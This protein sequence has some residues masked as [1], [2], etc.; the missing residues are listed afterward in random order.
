MTLVDGH[1]NAFR[2]GKGSREAWADLAGRLNV[3]E[4]LARAGIASDQVDTFSA[5]LQ[6]LAAVHKRAHG[7]AA[8]WT[9]RGPE[10]AALDDGLWM[11]RVQLQHCSQGELEHARQRV[12]RRMQQA[13][14]GN[15]G[16]DTQ[17]LHGRA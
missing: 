3:A 9:L 4:E 6:A 16:G 8:S 17:V 10:I 12:Q 13:L 2:L 14:A 1:M 7:C 5:A 15:V 11:H